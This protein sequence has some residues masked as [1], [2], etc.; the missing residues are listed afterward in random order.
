MANNYFVIDLFSGSGGSAQ[1]FKSAGFNIA[2]AVEI[3]KLASESF[4]N[5]FPETKLFTEDIRDI[6]G[7][8]LL[9]LTGAKPNE[10][11]VLALL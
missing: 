10:L 11:I 6:K 7:K 9:T 2:A 5:N 3:D 1:G 4:H 8:D